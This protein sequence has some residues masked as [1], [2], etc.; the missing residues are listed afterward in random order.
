M[1]DKRG[2]GKEQRWKPARHTQG[3]APPTKHTKRNH[4]TS[5]TTTT[6]AEKNKHSGTSWKSASTPE[7]TQAKTQRKHNQNHPTTNHSHTNHQPQP[8]RVNCAFL[9][10]ALMIHFILQ[11]SIFQLLFRERLQESHSP[12]QTT[13]QSSV[14]HMCN[15][16][17]PRAEVT[18]ACWVSGTLHIAPC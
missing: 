17:R 8:S 12:R 15:D 6:K 4:P 5:N 18:T 13:S 9:S 14:C 7:G 3:H 1:K 10:C 11:I 16:S 2:N